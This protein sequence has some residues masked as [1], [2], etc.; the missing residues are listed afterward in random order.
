MVV[1]LRLPLYH[2]LKANEHGHFLID[3]DLIENFT[4]WA[5]GI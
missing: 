4:P 3:S 1:M 2:Q 5:K